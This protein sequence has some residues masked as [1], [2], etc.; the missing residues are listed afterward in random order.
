ME[1]ADCIIRNAQVYTVEGA[2]PLARAVPVRD[3]LVAE[4]GTEK[5]IR[6]LAGPDTRVIELDPDHL[7]LPGFI[8]SHGHFALVLLTMRAGRI[9]HDVL[10][11]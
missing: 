2:Q 11:S 4:V 3:G 8:D 9:T 5:E 6:Y 10:S 7:V 1:P